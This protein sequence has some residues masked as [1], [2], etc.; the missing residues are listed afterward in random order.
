MISLANELHQ[1]GVACLRYNFLYMEQKKR[2]PD[3]PAVAHPA[4]AAAL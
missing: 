1:H 4:V 3:F 2:R